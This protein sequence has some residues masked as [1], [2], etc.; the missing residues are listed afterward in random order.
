MRYTWLFIV[1]ALVVGCG[2]N[3]P[4]PGGWPAYIA[5]HEGF[6]EEQWSEVLAG[7]AYLNNGCKDELVHPEGSGS[8]YPL[9]FKLVETEED[10]KRRAG[11]AIVEE[12]QC[13]IEI[14]KVVFS[15]QHA[16][17]RI[18]VIIHELGHCAGLDHETDSGAVMYRTTAALDSYSAGALDHFFHTVRQSLGL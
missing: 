6:S 4:I 11:L 3:R 16:R 15:E 9:H 10:K 17:V 1:C 2:K 18:P 7:V 5:G 8:G 14:S 13:T 12:E